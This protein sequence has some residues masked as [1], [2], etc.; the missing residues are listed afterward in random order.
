MEAIVYLAIASIVML[1]ITQIFISQT[2]VYDRETGQAD[3]ELYAKSALNALTSNSISALEVTDTHT[4]GGT[5]YASSSSTLILTLPSI[6][7]NQTM[8]AN[9]S[10]YVVF[11]LSAANPAMLY[12]KIDADVSSSRKSTTK[13]LASFVEGLNF[14]YN[15]AIPTDATKVE[16]ALNLSKVVRGVTHTTQ[17]STAIFLKNKF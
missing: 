4:F 14:R 16:V 2:Q 17:A 9:K 1:I 11:Y 10:D 7:A 5:S 15:V 3:I 6:D 8:I 12:M 13:L